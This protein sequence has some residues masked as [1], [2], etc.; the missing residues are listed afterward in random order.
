M[1]IAVAPSGDSLASF[2]QVSAYPHLYPCRTLFLMCLF[3]SQEL[4]KKG[5]KVVHIPKDVVKQ[6]QSVSKA[7][8][9]HPAPIT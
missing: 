2:G 1:R 3:S 9:S 6:A 8:V 4:E 5:F 7:S